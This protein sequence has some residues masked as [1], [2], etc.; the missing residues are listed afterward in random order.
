MNDVH[1]ASVCVWQVQTYVLKLVAGCGLKYHPLQ[2]GQDF[3]VQTRDK[4]FVNYSVTVPHMSS[5]CLLLK[6]YFFPLGWGQG[7][8]KHTATS[9]RRV[10][11]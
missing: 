3:P 1:T 7:Q 2:H 4:G 5:H 6:H 11:L 10:G 9:I 8:Y